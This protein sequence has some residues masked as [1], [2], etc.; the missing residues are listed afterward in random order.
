MY[1]VLYQGYKPTPVNQS[2]RACKLWID[3]VERPDFLV[4]EYEWIKM[5]PSDV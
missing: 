3:Q 1:K 2:S 5:V 4:N